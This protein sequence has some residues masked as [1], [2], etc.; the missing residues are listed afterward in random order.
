MQIDPVTY[1][2]AANHGIFLRYVM[3][4]VLSI[5]VADPEGRQRQLSVEVEKQGAPKSYLGGYRHKTT[6]TTFAC[7]F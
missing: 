4:S 2:G 1:V 3:P 7:I 6:G 5:T